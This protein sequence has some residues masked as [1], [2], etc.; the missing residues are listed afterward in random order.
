M[1][2]L[3]GALPFSRALIYSLVRPIA[4][5]MVSWVYPADT[6]AA[7]IVNFLA[8]LSPPSFID[9]KTAGG[10]E[11]PDPRDYDLYFLGLLRVLIL[12]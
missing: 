1:A 7:L 4:F 12:N 10:F 9:L 2:L 11:P 3:N 5:A 6:L 8:T